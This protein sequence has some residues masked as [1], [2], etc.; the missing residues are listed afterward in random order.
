MRC[1][2]DLRQNCL[3]GAERVGSRELRDDDGNGRLSRHVGVDAVVLRAQLDA[4]NIAEP[5]NPSLRVDFQN[6][7]TKLFRRL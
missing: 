6:D 3:R 7:L 1:V 2:L 4:S 5:R